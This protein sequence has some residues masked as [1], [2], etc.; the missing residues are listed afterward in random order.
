ML[1]HRPSLNSSV[2]CCFNNI[3][4]ILSVNTD[5]CK[6]SDELTPKAVNKEDK[7]HWKSMERSKYNTAI[8]FK[9]CRGRSFSSSDVIKAEAVC[10]SILWPQI[11]WLVYR[12]YQRLCFPI[13]LLRAAFRRHEP[14][15]LLPDEWTCYQKIMKQ[16]YLG[17]LNTV[18]G[19]NALQVKRVT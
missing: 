8:S 19:G 2:S 5:Q 7:L 12:H 16:S 13:C 3:P 15:C 17:P 14:T 4:I 11:S 10:A 18:L 6:H 9:R 1:T